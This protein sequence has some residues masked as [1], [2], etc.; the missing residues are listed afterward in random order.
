MLAICQFCFGQ[1]VSV[2]GE[3]LIRSQIPAQNINID[4]IFALL[5]D[6]DV[7]RPE[8]LMENLHLFSDVVSTSTLMSLLA[9]RS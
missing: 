6:P 3:P 7:G 2:R 9:G 1:C 5:M 4:I 8:R